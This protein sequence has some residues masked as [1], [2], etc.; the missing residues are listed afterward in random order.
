MLEGI[1]AEWI[2]SHGLQSG[3]DRTKNDR[4]VEKIFDTNSKE[5]KLLQERQTC[6]G[7]FTDGLQSEQHLGSPWR[8]G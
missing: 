6:T 8:G 5:S 3:M 2:Q 7:D 4:N 1:S